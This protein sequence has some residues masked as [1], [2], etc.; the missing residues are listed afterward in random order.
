VTLEI[1]EPGA[2][3]TVQDLGR[4]GYQRLGI[5]TAGAMDP[6]ALMAANVLAGNGPGAAALE[7]TMIGPRVRFL[8][9][10]IVVV[11]GGDLGLRI[12]GR[13]AETWKAHVVRS[14]SAIEFSGRRSGARAYLAVAGGI[15]L[16]PW[17]GSQSTYMMAQVG[18][19]EGRALRAGDRLPVGRCE[20][21]LSALSSRTIPVE[22][23]PPYSGEPVARVILGPHADRFTEEGI[24][25]FLGG[26]YEISSVSNRMGYRLAGPR[27]EHT[28]GA[29][30]ISCGIPLGGIQVP[31]NGQPIILMADHQTTGG[32]T[33]IAT[34]IQA[35]I[36]LVAQ[37]L[38]G[39]RLRFRSVDLE[40]AQASYRRMVGAINAVA[41]A[42]R[43]S[44]WE[45]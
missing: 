8:D 27:I 9:S 14:G 26:S 29:D 25:T 38:P 11:A 34:V 33:M 15:A 4:F 37:C 7:I 10:A 16:E 12:D 42:G 36:P 20:M 6:F 30:I 23:R 35:D 44:L 31:G 5:P 41:E 39:E 40:E 28:R 17:L 22:D 19:L 24:A 3:T 1:L 13:E 45:I 21:S 43:R 18:G 2:L 32:Y